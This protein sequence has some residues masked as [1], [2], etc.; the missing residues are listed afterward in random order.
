M[1]IKLAIFYIQ[2]TAFGL[3]VNT[4]FQHGQDIAHFG[5]PFIGYLQKWDFSDEDDFGA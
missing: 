1:N 5:G 4:F 3:F 2:A